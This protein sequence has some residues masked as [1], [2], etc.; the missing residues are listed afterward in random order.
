MNDEWLAD[1]KVG[2]P[3]AIRSGYGYAGYQLAK[4][5]K[6]TKTQ[7]VVGSSRYRRD[8]GRKVGHTGWESIYLQPITDTVMER[9]DRD[10]LNGILQSS[11]VQNLSIEK[12]R[13]I[14]AIVRSPE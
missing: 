9:V 13:K 2:D 1:L 3:C 10:K 6:M 4:V 14:L 7:I 5:E 12:V 8:N 11:G